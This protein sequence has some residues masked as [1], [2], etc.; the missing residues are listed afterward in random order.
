[1]Q[2]LKQTIIKFF[3]PKAGI[4]MI[5]LSLNQLKLVAKNRGTKDYKKKSEDDLIKIF[6]EP[7]ISLSKKRIKNIK[8]KFNEWRYKFSKSKINEIKRSLKDIKI[9]KKSLWIKN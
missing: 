4:I 5:N 2:H 6:S 9:A 1:M 3:F 8:K 7:K